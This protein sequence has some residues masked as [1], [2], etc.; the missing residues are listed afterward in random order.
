MISS[1]TDL[2]I[3]VNYIDN[4]NCID[5]TR[6][7]LQSTVDSSNS[8]TVSDISQENINES[9]QK[10]LANKTP[11]TDQTPVQTNTGH[12]YGYSED[13]GHQEL[14]TRIRIYQDSF[15]PNQSSCNENFPQKIPQTPQ[16]TR[17][18]APPANIRT[19]PPRPS[20]RTSTPHHGY[21]QNSE[22]LGRE[23][24]LNCQL[25]QDTSTTIRQDFHSDN[26]RNQASDEPHGGT[27]QHGIVTDL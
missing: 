11:D 27:E 19:A 13:M 12:Q 23:M 26:S 24:P 21:Q 6:P 16:D 9:G 22:T 3:S 8:S 18:T 14:P 20:R 2:N 15:Q 7:L 4:E 10:S 1:T 5:L 17:R 25:L